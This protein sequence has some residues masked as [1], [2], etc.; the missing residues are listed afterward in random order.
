MDNQRVI[1]QK[2]LNFPLVPAAPED[3]LVTVIQGPYW[4]YWG[5]GADEPEAVTIEMT[6]WTVIAIE[7]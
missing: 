4:W 6:D 7:P 5:W 1:L 2:G 3:I